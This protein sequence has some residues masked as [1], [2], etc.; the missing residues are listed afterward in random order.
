M[1]AAPVVPASPAPTP[2][3]APLSQ[4]ARIIDTFIAPS[5]TF[6]DIRRSAQWW[7]PFLLMVVMSTIFVYTAGQK[8]GF[9]KIVENQM[10]SQPKAQERFEKM[11]PEQREGQIK[12]TGNSVVR[13]NPARHA[14]HLADHGGPAV[15]N[16]Q[17][18]GQC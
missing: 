10:Q 5:K 8:I 17:V 16:L 12:W 13:S 2:Q 6:T 9:H 4:G 15:C 7:A 11:T 18:R 14:H 1:A 3:P